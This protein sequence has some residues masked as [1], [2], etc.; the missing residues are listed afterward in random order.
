M[1]AATRIAM[2][3]S[4]QIAEIRLGTDGHIFLTQGLC[5]ELKGALTHCAEE[6]GVRV[7]ILTGANAGVFMRHYSV[8]E[9][10]SISAQLKS[11]GRLTAA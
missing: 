9:I 7:V 3:I 4:E 1:P 6:E 2:T 10:L 11:P 8:A 5:E